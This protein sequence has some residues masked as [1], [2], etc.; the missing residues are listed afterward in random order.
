MRHH[1]ILLFELQVIGSILLAGCA[2]VD[3]RPD[4]DRAEQMIATRTGVDRAYNPEAASAIEDGVAALLADG[5]TTDEA[6][7]VALLSNR[8]F[9]ALFQEIGVSRAN[10]VQSG[11]LSNPS[12]GLSARFPEAGGRS[13]L[14]VTFAQQ[15]ADL[16]Q[17]PVRKRI[18][19][20]ALEQTILNIVHAANNLASDARR[21]CYRVIALKQLEAIS[22]ETMGLASKSLK[23]GRGPV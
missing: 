14:T 19:E 17:I 6:V 12:I 18:A 4:F 23:R 11:L 2:T 22:L 7:Q 1:Q 3:P 10:V 9:Q 16:W 20:A 15:I 13:N 5:L 21:D 8:Q